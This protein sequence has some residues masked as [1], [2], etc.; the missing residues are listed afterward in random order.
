MFLTHI[1]RSKDK[2][3]VQQ[4]IEHLST[5]V[6]YSLHVDAC[7]CWFLTN[8]GSSANTCK[9]LTLL[10]SQIFQHWVFYS[11]KY[12]HMFRCFCCPN[13]TKW[14][15]IILPSGAS[16]CCTIQKTS[17]SILFSHSP[18]PLKLCFIQQWSPHFPTKPT[19]AEGITVQI[20]ENC[21]SQG[22]VLSGE[23]NLSQKPWDHLDVLYNYSSFNC[24]SLFLFCIVPETMF[25]VNMLSHFCTSS[26]INHINPMWNHH[27][28]WT[29]TPA[30]PP[31]IAL[32]LTL[33]G[34]FWVINSVYLRVTT[35][36]RTITTQWE[37]H[38]VC[39]CQ[40]ESHFAG[41]AWVRQHVFFH[42]S[43]LWWTYPKAKQ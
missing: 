34:A 26:T 40:G 39:G 3:S 22:E 11:N 17:P 18:Q 33:K 12:K 27:I 25:N 2:S 23:L 24:V 9:H 43:P 14:T 28:D 29:S 32:L 30:P 21:L 37:S 7:S 1:I 6:D 36:F 41:F 4:C 38:L 16:A 5:H 42:C 31:F 8:L 35:T 13:D 15:C 10:R 20:L 19:W